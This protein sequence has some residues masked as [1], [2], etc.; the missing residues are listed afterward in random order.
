MADR[1]DPF[2]IFNDPD[3]RSIHGI[4]PSGARFAK[5]RSGRVGALLG[6]SFVRIA[7]SIGNG[8][9]DD[10]IGRFHAYFSGGNAGARCLFRPLSRNS[11][12]A[13]PYEGRKDRYQQ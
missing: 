6:L 11:G 9:I 10:F 1:Q 5:F 2:T 3:L 8:G 4:S 12:Y 7:L 13:A